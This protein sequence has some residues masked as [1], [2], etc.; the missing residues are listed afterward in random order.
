[1]ST[2]AQ[3]VTATWRSE[4]GR[5]VG[6]L[7]RLTGDLDLAEDLAQDALV[8]ALEQRPE[9]GIPNNPAAWLLTTAR[10][11][12]IDGFR[13]ADAL[14]RKTTELGHA[15]VEVELMPEVDFVAD[16]V[17]RLMFLTCHPTLPPASRAALTLRLVSGL[18]TGEIARAF[19]VPETTMGQRISRAKKSLVGIDM[20]V[21]AGGERVARVDDVLAA[22]YLLFNE[23]YVATTGTDW[24]RPDLCHEAIRLS[25]M[26]ASMVP[27][28]PDVLALQALLELQASRLRARVDGDGRP[29]LLEDQDRRQWDPLLRRRGLAVL[30]R[31]AA[32]AARGK[33]VGSY[34]LQAAIAGEHAR[35]ADVEDT[36]WREIARLYDV[37]AAAAPGPV[38]EANRAVAH[39]RAFGPQAG[40]AVL[41]AIPGG[42]LARSPLVPAV[43]ADLLLR[44]GDLAAAEAGFT[45]AATRSANDAERS[46]LLKRAAQA[47]HEI[48][49]RS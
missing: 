29:V 19:L 13:R 41:D 31:A 34:F 1:M 44:A 2:T 46:L 7:A 4:S 11:R 45:E 16:D 24:A 39:G 9:R 22:V 20:D 38:V 27:D 23:G 36:D 15:L 26:L 5:L 12:A 14:R 30:D 3:A 32:L 33:P 10:R 47:R 21:P 8:A 35:A 49:E 43:R 37:L 42:A 28:V 48:E 18:S 6:A 40:L 25:R 17:L